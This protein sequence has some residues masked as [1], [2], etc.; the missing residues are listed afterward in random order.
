M[1]EEFEEIFFF[2]L[3][4]YVML[5]DGVKEVIVFL[6]ER[7]IKI[8]LIMGYMREMMEIVVKEVVL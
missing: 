1:Y 5:I 2:I 6:C 8:G 7:G 3:L 4:S